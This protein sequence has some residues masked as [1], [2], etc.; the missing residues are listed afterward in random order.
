MC[1]TINAESTPNQ[2][3]STL[4]PPPPLTFVPDMRFS[5]AAAWLALLK[6]TKA[7]SERRTSTAWKPAAVCVFTAGP[8]GGGAGPAAPQQ[9]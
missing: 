4:P 7:M 5:A 1:H 9:S 8:A 6:I 2:R 3:E